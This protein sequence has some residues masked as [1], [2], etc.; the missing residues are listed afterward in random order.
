L[1]PLNDI[2]KLHK[3]TSDTQD[4]NY[5]LKMDESIEIATQ[6]S[7]FEENMKKIENITPVLKKLIIHN[8]K[9]VIVRF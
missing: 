4:S 7:L 6:R 3:F 8:S 2:S 1:F 9:N 5:Q